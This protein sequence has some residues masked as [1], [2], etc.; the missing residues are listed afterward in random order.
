[1]N[2]PTQIDPATH[3][4]A[5]LFLQK[6][7]KQFSIAGAFLFGSRARRTHRPE[8][9]ADIAVL[10]NGE[11][12]RF[13]PTKLAMADTAFEVLLETGIRIQPLPVWLDEWQDPEHYSNP[14]LLANIAKEGIAL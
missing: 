13:L 2:T 12:A 8:S 14:Q 10:L 6:I 5:Q 4:A 11:H 3:Y 1:M 9:D 7:A